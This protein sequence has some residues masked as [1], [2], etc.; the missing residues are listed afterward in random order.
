MKVKGLIPII[1]ASLL[2]GC[3]PSEEGTR[4]D[5]GRESEGTVDRYEDDFRP[6]DHDPDV[7]VLLGTERDTTHQQGALLPGMAPTQ[8]SNVVPGFRVQLL[9]SADFSEAHAKKV[10]AE[11]AFP[12]EWIYLIYDAPTYKIRVGNFVTRLEADRF[13]RQ[14]VERGYSDAWI[15][16]EKVFSKPPSPPPPE[17]I[18]QTN[19]EQ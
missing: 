1:C 2:F 9:S 18:D 15:V 4:A 13:L 6:A 10:E 12:H 11:S 14:A 3:G 5:A 16:P 7:H 17:T 8:S 19:R